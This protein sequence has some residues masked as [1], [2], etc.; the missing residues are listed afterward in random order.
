M[1]LRPVYLLALATAV[2]ACG[3]GSAPP[4]ARA[5]LTQRQRDSAVGASALPGARGVGAAIGAADRLDAR[6]RTADSVGASAP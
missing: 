6:T 2:A 5:A 1:P 3:G 4:D